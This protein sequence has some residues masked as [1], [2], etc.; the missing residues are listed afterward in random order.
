MTLRFYLLFLLFA[1]LIGGANAKSRVAIWDP[2][3]GTTSS[4]FKIDL[5]WLNH[6]EKWLRE[7]GV[8]TARLT[9]DQI[10]NPVDFSATNFA[11]I[12]LPGDAFPRRNTTALQRFAL[13]GGILISLGAGPVP[14]LTAIENDG[15]GWRPAP[16]APD[17][18]WETSDI[19]DK[20]LGLIYNDVPAR[21]EDGV[22]HEATALFKKYLT[23][24][25]EAPVL[26]QKL[27][28]RW[29]VPRPGTELYPLIRSRRADGH[30]TV[31]QLFIVRNKTP[32]GTKTGF[33][34][35]SDVFTQT[36]NAQVWPLIQET[37]VAL[38]KIAVDLRNNVLPLTPHDKIVLL[39]EAINDPE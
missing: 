1:L 8:E 12:I 2:E 28:S 4:R 38:A 24:P 13:E 11:A 22:H 20:V 9:A 31:P 39:D 26:Q 14:F 3:T 23:A 21:R 15:T 35:V 34:A 27:P 10:E 33:V 5:D 19:Y 29:L 32:E 36:K 37:V 18:A 7:G 6:V 16:V 25:P 30:D 17:R